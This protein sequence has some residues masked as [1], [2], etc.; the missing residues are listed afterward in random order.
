[1]LKFSLTQLTSVQSESTR[2]HLQVAF[3][4]AENPPPNTKTIQVF[5]VRGSVFPQTSIIFTGF[6]KER[7]WNMRN[8]KE[9]HFQI[10]CEM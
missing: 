4:C 7:A 8:I 1:M 3:F 5:E 6:R 9:S 2:P 10:P